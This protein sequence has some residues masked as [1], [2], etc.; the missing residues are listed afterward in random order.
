MAIDTRAFFSSALGR[1]VT[2]ILL[3]VCAFFGFGPDQWVRWVMPGP[4]T[5]L[6]VWVARLIFLFFGSVGLVL[7]VSFLIRN[8][9]T[10]KNAPERISAL[11]FFKEAAK[12]GIDFCGKSHAILHLC[13]ALQQAASEG[14]VQLWGKARYQTDV[15]LQIPKEHWFESRIYWESAFEI[16]HPGEIKAGPLGSDHAK[17]TESQRFVPRKSCFSALEPHFLY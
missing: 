4:D 3:A 6:S 8:E 12:R 7:W 17:S 5:D 10:Y 2:A 16:V 9:L 13:R 11:D 14:V 15:F 1:I